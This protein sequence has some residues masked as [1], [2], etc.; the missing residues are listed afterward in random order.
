MLKEIAGFY[1]EEDNKVITFPRCKYESSEFKYDLTEG[2]RDHEEER[3]KFEDRFYT[4]GRVHINFKCVIGMPCTGKTYLLNK[5]SAYEE[6]L[7]FRN[8]KNEF[9]MKSPK[10]FKCGKI[11]DD[12]DDYVLVNGYLKGVNATALSGKIDMDVV[13]FLHEQYAKHFP[14]DNKVFTDNQFSL[15]KMFMYLK[16]ALEIP[17]VPNRVFIIDDLNYS[18]EISRRMIDTMIKCIN[19]FAAPTLKSMHIVF[20][21]NIPMILTDLLKHDVISLK[22]K[23]SERADIKM[24]GDNLLDLEYLFQDRGAGFMGTFANSKID[25]VLEKIDDKSK[26]HNRSLEEFKMIADSIGDRNIRHYISNLLMMR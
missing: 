22:M 9:V 21:T 14:I 12:S 19:K 7:I 5:M 6:S 2:C 17:N 15:I 8:D 4:S 11:E 10:D 24:F 13:N 18:I 16:H 20:S 25:N 23:P 3:K 26:R 1:N